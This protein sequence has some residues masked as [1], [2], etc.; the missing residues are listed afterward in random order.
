MNKGFMLQGTLWRVSACLPA[1]WWPSFRYVWPLCFVIIHDVL[2]G[3]FGAIGRDSLARSVDNTRRYLFNKITSMLTVQ[4]ADLRRTC[5]MPTCRT[6]GQYVMNLLLATYGTGWICAV[7]DLQHVWLRKP[8]G[9]HLLCG[10]L[11]VVGGCK[12]GLWQ[13]CNGG[14]QGRASRGG[15]AWLDHHRGLGAGR[16][17]CYHCWSQSHQVR[18]NSGV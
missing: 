6:W 3:G 1:W 15:V 4:I 9:L 10:S 7:R 16:P 13:V 8:A 2:L 12:P 18:F 11:R 14:K 17:V 5:I